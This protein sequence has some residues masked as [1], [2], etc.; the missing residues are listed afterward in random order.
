MDNDALPKWVTNG[1]KLSHW[2]LVQ[3]LKLFY[4]RQSVKKGKYIYRQKIEEYKK[5]MVS[6]YKEI[7]TKQLSN[8]QMDYLASL[9]NPKKTPIQ[10]ISAI[11]L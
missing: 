11:H 10:I 5:D 1:K 7:L 4:F 6:I 9:E 3:Q 2:K 8:T